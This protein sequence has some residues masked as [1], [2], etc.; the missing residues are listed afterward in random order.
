MDQGAK[1]LS[2]VASVIDADDPEDAQKIID[3]IKDPGG[4]F[5]RFGLAESLLRRRY[6]P[7]A[8]VDVSA[9]APEAAETEAT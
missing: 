4:T 3:Q 5:Y 8:N 6:R 2:A 7:E 1:M 9:P